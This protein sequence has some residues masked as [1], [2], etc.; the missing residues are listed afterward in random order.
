YICRVY[1]NKDGLTRIKPRNEPVL[2]IS[3]IKWGQDKLSWESNSGINDSMTEEFFLSKVFSEAMQPSH[4]I[5]YYFRADD[6]PEEEDITIT[7]LIT[8]N[9]FSVFDKLVSHYQGPIS[10]TIHVSDDEETRDELLNSLNNLY[11]SNPYMKKYVDVHL[12]VDRFERQFNMWR[13][14]AKFFARTNY[15]MMLDVDFHPCTN[16]RQKILRSPRIMKM[17]RAGNT[18]LV[19]P[20]F[21]YADLNEGLNHSTFPTTKKDALKLIDSNRLVMF[22]ASWKPG[23][24]S[25]NYDAWHHT[26]VLYKVTHYQ[27]QYEPYV[28]FP[29][30]SAWCDER[31]VGYGANK[32]A[33]LFELYLS[34][35]NYWVLPEDFLIHQTHEYLETARKHE[36]MFNRRLY[37]NFR[38]EICFRYAR[39]FILNNEWNTP[40]SRNL[41]EACHK[42][43]G[44][45]QAIKFYKESIS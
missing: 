17:L 20:A 31:F 35:V 41:R 25:S 36:R 9:R 44:F 38:E 28:I 5:P 40:K 42:I 26:N 29:K 6:P 18:A 2:E 43:R 21:E 4:V 37:D 30:N 1:T 45:T 19:I 27:Y 7:T 14:V 16:F 10:V 33:C 32:A 12:V 8:S 11:N 39:N 23:H 3:S 15:V 24:G 22:H 13:N 34:G